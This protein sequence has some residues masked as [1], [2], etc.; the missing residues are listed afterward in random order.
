M[1]VLLYLLLSL[2]QVK[3]VPRPIPKVSCVM[4]NHSY[5]V[6]HFDKTT[7]KLN[8]EEMDDWWVGG[9][10]SEDKSGCT[11]TVDG[12]VVYDAPLATAHPTEYRDAMDA[13]DVF[14]KKTAGE[15]IKAL[16]DK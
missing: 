7:G 2:K 15:I 14:R 12:K 16:R 3:P 13:I 1:E 9:F 6:S 10:N 11:I 4:N 8:E 5:V